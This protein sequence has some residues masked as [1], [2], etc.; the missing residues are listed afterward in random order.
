ML[1]AEA[2]AQDGEVGRARRVSLRWRGH[3]DG[4]SARGWRAVEGQSRKDVFV[5]SP[6]SF[7]FVDHEGPVNRKV[8]E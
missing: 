4:M 6:A 2:L 1:A 8:R 5:L 7:C 3:G